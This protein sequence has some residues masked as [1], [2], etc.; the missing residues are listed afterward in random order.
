MPTR[1]R[2]VRRVLA[3]GI[4]V[5]ALPFAVPALAAKPA[6]PFGGTCST[7]VVPVTPPSTVPQELSIATD[8]TL[9][10][11]GRTTGITQQF[12]TPTG[13]S[14]AGVTLSLVNSTVYTAAN[15]DQ[16]WATFTGT[17]LLDPITGDVSYVGIEVYQGGTGRFADASGSTHLEGTASVVSNRGLFTTKGKLSY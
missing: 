12:V 17:A 15:G 1:A 6:R 16:L 8:C 13:A 10:H 2:F 11:L 3:T 5:L 4:L 9:S 14:P 7:V